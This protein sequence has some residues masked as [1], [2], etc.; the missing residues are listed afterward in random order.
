[1]WRNTGRVR[2]RQCIMDFGIIMNK[3]FLKRLTDAHSWLGLII[4]GLLFVVFF[5]GSIS[6]FK[7]EILQWS[8]QPHYAM[9]QGE[10]LSVSQ[11]MEK[12]IVGLDFDAKEHLTIVFPEPSMPYYQAF[13]DVHHQPGEPDYVSFYIDPVTGQRLAN[14]ESFSLAQ[15]I[16]DLHVDLNIPAGKYVIGFVT[17]FFFF[18]LVSGIIIHARKLIT[19]FFKYRSDSAPRS[20]LLDMHNVIGVMSLPITVMYAISG[21]IFN[22]V[23]IYQIS[24]ALA[25]YGGDQQA[26]L[27]DAGFKAVNVEWQDK[28]WHQPPIDELTLQ[29]MDKYNVVP[30]VARVYNY[31]DESAAIQFV[32]GEM[33]SLTVKYDAAF[34]LSDKR[35]LFTNDQESPNTLVTGLYVVSKLHFGNFAGIDLRI[36]YF[37]LGMGVCALIISGNLLWIEKR[38]RQRQQSQKTLKFIGNF[39]LWSTGGVIVATSV[40]FVSERL[41]PFDLAMRQQYMM[42]SF[43]IALIIVGITLGFNHNKLQ[44]L[45]KLLKTSACLLLTVI[46]LDWVLHPAQ[47]I[48]LTGQQ[49]YSVIGTQ[50]G[51]LLMATILAVSGI[52]LTRKTVENEQIDEPQTVSAS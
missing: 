43:V 37:F 26:L 1:M 29:V 23:I 9:P 20:K 22:L 47:I 38:S 18:A 30:R 44:F 13:V 51:L 3:E 24:I 17:L 49:V 40:A 39:T 35:V 7:N 25:L 21:L 8:M 2:Q 14:V 15:F 36:L 52:K 4:S 27:D 11:I 19:N 28:A 5:A 12:S 33:Q 42:S 32:G 50:V 41:L 6:L 48:E 45:A 31:G 46:A 34:S 10:Q 16:Y